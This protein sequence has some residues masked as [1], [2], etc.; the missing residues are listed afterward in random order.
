MQKSLTAAKVP[1]I[2]ESVEL[3]CTNNKHP[4]GATI[5]PRLTGQPLAWDVTILDTFAVSYLHLLS[6]GVGQVAD[7]A[8]RWKIDVYRHVARSHHFVPLTFK[9]SGVF[10]DH[11]LSFL[12]QLASRIWSITKDPIEYL[13]RSAKESVCVLR[14]WCLAV[15]ELGVLSASTFRF[16]ISRVMRTHV[17]YH[18]F[19]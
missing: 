12:H 9:S 15:L 19:A 10:G 17:L 16:A 6:A 11:S 13:K 4:D 7:V 14:L 1:F 2:L 8:A 3:S 5:I 18:N